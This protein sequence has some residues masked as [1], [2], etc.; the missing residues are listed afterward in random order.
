MLVDKEDKI[1]SEDSLVSEEINFFFQN[2]TNSFD[3]NKNSY[4]KDETN[5]Y[6]D[7][8]ENAIYIYVNHRSILLIKDNISGVTPF[9]FKEASLE[10]IE[11]GMLHLNPKKASTFQ[12]IP[13]KILKNSINVC[14]ETLKIFFDTVIHCEFPNELKKSDVTPISKKD[15]PTKTKNY[16]PVSVLPVALKVFERIMHKQISEYINQ[17]LLPYLCSYRPGFSTQQAHVSLI[18][19][20]KAISD[21]SRYAGAVLM[22]LSKAFD[23]I[24][25]DLLI[26]KLNA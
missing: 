7:T 23:T 26:A 18:E 2:A 24:N 14:S 19:K 17:F 5:K 25:H 22:H 4:I 8:V 6:V 9:S 1:I 20:R 13:P 12:D 3:I 10:D 21:K 16:R 11:K 15:D